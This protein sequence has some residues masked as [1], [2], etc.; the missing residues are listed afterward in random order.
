MHPADR[1]FLPLLFSALALLPG[2]SRDTTPTDNARTVLVHV[3]TDA[4]SRGSALTGEVRARHEVELAFRVGGKIS[5]RLVDTGS[6]IR[7]GQPLARLDPTDLQLSASAAAAQLRAA[8]SEVATS[9][10]ERER[11]ADLLDKKFVSQT[12]Y[13]TR[14]HAFNSARARLE[15]AQAQQRISSNQADYGTLRSDFPAV[16]SAVLADTGQVVAAGQPVFRIA[17]PEEKEILIAVPESRIDEIR[18]VR[19]FAVH[20]W[21]DP[22]TVIAGRLRELGAVADVQTRTYPAR[23]RLLDPPPQVHLGMTARVI[24]ENA[25]SPTP[26]YPLIPLAALGDQGHGP[27]VWVVK[28]GKLERRAVRVG[29]FREDGAS[30]VE[31]LQS[32]ESVVIAGISRL[33]EG[34]A[35]VAKTAPAPAAQR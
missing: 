1:F 12:A 9:A 29:E 14:L 22:K 15:Q 33:V 10:A 17:R 7:A 13:D 3:A 5:A 6:E 24:A 28:A 35:V 25:E 23:I 4:P 19:N 34:Q 18:A 27:F 11:Y 26:A 16:V 20:L 8:E 21:A 32:G 31:G 30:I 2:C